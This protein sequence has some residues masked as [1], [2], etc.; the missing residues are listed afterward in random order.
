VPSPPASGTGGGEPLVIFGEAEREA[1]FSLDATAD[2]SAPGE[3]RLRGALEHGGGR[4]ELPEVRWFS[5]A[6]GLFEI[7]LPRCPGREDVETTPCWAVVHGQRL[8][9]LTLRDL[10]HGDISDAERIRAMPSERVHELDAGAHGLVAM[11]CPVSEPDLRSTWVAWLSG[12]TLHAGVAFHLFHEVRLPLPGEP[13][14]IVGVLARD[15]GGAD[16]LVLRDD[17]RALW[18]VRCAGP[19]LRDEAPADAGA[20]S[21]DDDLADPRER[22]HAE[23]PRLVAALDLPGP[24]AHAST[25]RGGGS[26]ARITGLVMA[27]QR[28]RDVEVLYAALEDDTAPPRWR[29]ARIEEARLLSGADPV[30]SIDAR[31]VARVSVLFVDSA[32]HGGLAHMAF[33]PDG[34]PLWVRGVGRVDLGPI[35]GEPTAAGLALYVDEDAGER[36]CDWAVLL[37]GNVLWAGRG[38]GHAPRARSSPHAIARPVTVWALAE[39]SAVA[40]C[41]DGGRLRFV[42]FD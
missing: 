36:R 37:P 42:P 10:V 3:Y 13:S 4:W 35:P 8:T 32:G 25:A 33:A 28:G 16:L 20:E 27:A 24:V 34:E 18:R 39:G 17:G 12:R 41:D 30:V 11:E 6:A 7:A 38:G 5:E 23:A 26:G 14:R 22:V 40:A 1:R 19:V 21:D 29:A 2:V 9:A 15:D 31:G